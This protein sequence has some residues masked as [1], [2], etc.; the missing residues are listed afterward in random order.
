MQVRIGARVPEK[1]AVIEEGVF[2]NLVA[3]YWLCAWMGDYIQG[4]DAGDQQR[5]ESA[6]KELEKY[7]TLPSTVATHQN[8]EDFVAHV[9]DPAKG[10]DAANLREFFSNS[11]TGYQRAVDSFYADR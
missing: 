6:I 4:M 5:G 8:P 3:G 10:D 11:C 2:D 7:T 9:I 1:D